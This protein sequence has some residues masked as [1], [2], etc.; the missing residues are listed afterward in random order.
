ME[1]NLVKRKNAK[2]KN[3]AAIFWHY[4]YPEMG[5]VGNLTFQTPEV[6]G[7]APSLNVPGMFV[8]HLHSGRQHARQSRES[9]QSSDGR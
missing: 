3:L 9:S 6:A 2:S 5:A 4:P 7:I 1:Q 8:G